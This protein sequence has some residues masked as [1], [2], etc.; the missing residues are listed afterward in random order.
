MALRS[1]NKE[2]EKRA[3][4]QIVYHLVL[5]EN[6][7]G[8]SQQVSVTPGLASEGAFVFNPSDFV[9]CYS[10]QWPFSL[11]VRVLD[12]RGSQLSRQTGGL[13]SAWP[14]KTV[15]TVR[16]LSGCRT[17]TAELPV[18]YA[19]R[20]IFLDHAEVYHLEALYGARKVVVHF[21]VPSESYPS[22]WK[23]GLLV[24]ATDI[25]IIVHRWVAPNLKSRSKGEARVEEAMRKTLGSLF[26][27]IEVSRRWNRP[28]C[29]VGLERLTP[30]A[31]G[32]HT[33]RDSQEKS[34]E[35]IVGTYLHA[36]YPPK[37]SNDDKKEC[38]NSYS[39]QFMTLDDYREFMGEHQFQ[40]ETQEEITT[41]PSPH[42]LWNPRD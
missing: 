9:R 34:I 6:E 26:R 7:D 36:K 32:L 2:W 41:Q 4:K 12:L 29:I 28:V 27:L 31:L 39:L 16:L 33:A 20:A 38:G 5:D 14:L 40:I 25:V 37:S 13:L 23:W 18:I 24:C 10:D 8:I 21:S 11:D 42:P 30:A 1:A 3:T 35:G 22:S 19:N 17:S 15:D